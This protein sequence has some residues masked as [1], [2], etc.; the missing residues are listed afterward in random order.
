MAISWTPDLT[1]GVDAIDKQHKIWF[2]KADDLFDAGK[3]GKSKEIIGE[4]LDFLDSYTKQHF[5][6]EEQYMMSIH[7]PEYATQKKL[8]TGFIAELAKLKESYAQSGGNI[9][10]I[11]N[12]NRMVIDWLTNHISFHDRKIGKFAATLKK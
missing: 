3:T 4:L 9:I 10:V 1:V 5:A 11:M 8:H 2:E 12:A 7:Y 6:D